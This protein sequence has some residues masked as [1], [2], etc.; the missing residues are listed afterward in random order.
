ML[1]NIIH[2][3]F[4]Y[5][6]SLST[7]SLRYSIFNF[8]RR[9]PMA[10]SIKEQSIKVEDSHGDT[11]FVG[12]PERI[13]RFKRGIKSKVEKVAA[14]YMLQSIGFETGDIIIDCGANIGEIG[15]YLKQFHIQYHAFEPALNEF[16]A[17]LKNNPQGTINRYALWKEETTLT[18]YNKNDTGDSSLF[19]INDYASKVTVQTKVLDDYIQQKNLAKIKLLKLEAEG[20]EPEILEG[21]L[22][23]LEKI[24]YISVDCGPE[25]GLNQTT[26]FVE[27]VN[28]LTSHGFKVKGIEQGRLVVLFK[29]TN[30]D[31]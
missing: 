20:A 21:A 12:E 8:F 25:R 19:E 27:V 4:L 31:K 23:S 1:K 13:Q 11:I 22:K 28:T 24:Q 17:N 6:G 16:E 18:F 29:N 9:W 30:I 14:N 10:I 7:F 26:T 3:K 2:N 5:H 15:I